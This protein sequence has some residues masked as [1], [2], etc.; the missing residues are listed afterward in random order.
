M[1]DVPEWTVDHAT[2]YKVLS[3]DM[4]FYADQHFKVVTVFL[5]TSG[6]LANVVKDKPSV[7]LCGFGALLALLCLAWDLGTTRWW[8][9]L[10]TQCQE[11]EDLAIAS[12]RMVRGYNRYRDQIQKTGLE[13]MPFPRPSHVVAL[14]YVLGFLGWL[15]FG[16]LFYVHRGLSQCLNV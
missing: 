15:W 3:D 5:V 1:P 6:L 8:G 14:L 9:T 2:Q 16:V 11:L 13:K 10:I 7:I 12:H 4:R